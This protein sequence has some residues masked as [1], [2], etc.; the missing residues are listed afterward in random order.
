MN[1]E[2]LKAKFDLYEWVESLRNISDEV[3]FTPFKEGSWATAD[4]I[5]H[6]ISWD[7]FVINNRVNPLLNGEPFPTVNVEVEDINKKAMEYAR[8]GISKDD[9]LSE[10]SLKRKELISLLGRIPSNA[11][12][13]SFM[14]HEKMTLLDYLLELRNH[15]QHHKEQIDHL[16]E[17]GKCE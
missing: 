5:S 16:I 14:G 11:L 8:S 10:F 15:D 13:K 3:W 17:H 2:E 12:E 6:L 1:R 9:L 7:T 4:V